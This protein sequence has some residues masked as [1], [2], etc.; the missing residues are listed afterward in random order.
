MMDSNLS[1]ET[2]FIVIHDQF[3]LALENLGKDLHNK[4]EVNFYEFHLK[5]L[6]AV[7]KIVEKYDIAQGK[8]PL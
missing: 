5:N 8:H 2:E 7:D 1:T 4:L 6:K 3:Q